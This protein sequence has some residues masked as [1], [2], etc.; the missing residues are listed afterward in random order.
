MAIRSGVQGSRVEDN[1]ISKGNKLGHLYQ[2]LGATFT[3]DADM[4]HLITLDPGGA[5]RTVLLPPETQGLWFILFNTADA[6]ELLTV[7]ED[8]GVTTIVTL[9]Q[10]EG[11]LLVCGFNEAGALEWRALSPT[12]VGDT[13]ALATLTASSA[14]VSTGTIAAGS[15]ATDRVTMKGIYL[16][17]AVVSVSVPSITDPDIARVNVDVSAAFSMQPAVGDAVIAIPAEALPTNCRLQ[18]AF[19]SATDEIEICFGSEGG[20]VVGAA[21]NFKFLVIDLT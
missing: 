4:P 6:S 20:S 17:P 10:D 15:D 21:K 7:K 14:L 2:K 9:N 8:S 5:A 12:G 11:A 1:T 19:V 16:T 13:L 3:M 18:G